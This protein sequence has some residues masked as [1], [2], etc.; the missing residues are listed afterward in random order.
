MLLQQS[1]IDML[2]DEQMAEYERENHTEQSSRHLEL[3]GKKLYREDPTL[4]PNSQIL[5]DASSSITM[6]EPSILVEEAPLRLCC[7]RLY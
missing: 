2:L 5:D 3:G 4:S 1:D 7:F 6:P